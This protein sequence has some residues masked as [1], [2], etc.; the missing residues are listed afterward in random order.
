MLPLSYLVMQV[1][2]RFSGMLSLSSAYSRTR[3]ESRCGLCTG[4]EMSR[5]EKGREREHGPV[6]GKEEGKQEFTHENN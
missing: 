1:H 3:G 4:K 5:K 6:Q 2:V